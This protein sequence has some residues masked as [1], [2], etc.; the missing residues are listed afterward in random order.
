MN[1]LEICERVELLAIPYCEDVILRISLFSNP[2]KP[3]TYLQVSTCLW[4]FIKSISL[5]QN[6]EEG[7][8]I[9]Q[10]KPL[11]QKSART[12]KADCPWL[13]SNSGEYS[14]GAGRPEKK[15]VRLCLDTLLR[16]LRHG[17]K[18]LI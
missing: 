11:P 18:A 14:M 13:S 15:K 6:N 16:T 12:R 7:G 1:L 2:L 8:C 3:T 4:P 10:Q 5:T 9:L 17:M